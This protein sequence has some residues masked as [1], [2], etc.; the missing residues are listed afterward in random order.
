MHKPI[1]YPA[2][3]Q[4]LLDK[5]DQLVPSWLPN[6]TEKSGRWYIGDL[7]GSPGKSCNI[8]LHTG[9]WID[10]GTDEKGGDL[11]SLY[12]AIRGLQMGEAA[13]ELMD[14]LGLSREQPKPV[15]TSERPPSRRPE[16]PPADDKPAARRTMWRSV[17]P[18]PDNARPPDF[19]HDHHGKADQVWE[20]KLD[21]KLYGYVCRFDKPPS[22]KRPNGGKEIMPRTWCVD[23]SDGNGHQR[24]HWKQWDEPRP[25]Y[26]P[27][28]ILAEDSRVTPVVIVEGEKCAMAAFELL[29]HEFDFISWPGGGKAWSYADWSWIKGRVVYLWPDCDA[30]RERLTT[31]D[32]AAGVE[33]SSKPIMD[34]NRQP[35]LQTMVG[36]GSLLVADHGCTVLMCR[37]PAPGA[38]SDGWDVAD[39]I[40]SG[41]DADTV[42]GFIRGAAAFTPPSD[43]ARAKAAKPPTAPSDAGAGEVDDAKAWRS[44]LILSSTGAIKAVRENVVLA[45]DGM[46]G[47]PGVP[48]AQGVIAY[49]EFTNDIIKLKPTPWG[50][51]AGIWEEVD[52][53]LVG[54]WLVR[55]HW[56]PSM[57][58]GTL[59]EAI[60][61]VAYRH[62]YHP[63]RNWL[64]SLKWDGEKR[65]ATW[66]RRACLEEDEW[67]DT[68]PLQRYLA[69]VGTW[70][71]TGMC[72]RV[73]QP[74]YKFDYMLILEGS[75]GR[76][77]ST[78]L[79]TLAGDWFADTG[80]VLG[81][82]DS[83]QQLQGRWLYEFGE[84]DSFG[85][86]EV[87]KIKSFVASSS[88][89]FRASFDRRA[90]DYPRQVVFGGTTNEDHYLTDPTGNRRFWPV[91]V[92][93]QIDIDWIT[94][95]R[96]QLFAEAME[97]FR[98]GRRNFPLPEEEL[99]LFEPQ[100]RARAVE[101]AIESALYRHL[102]SEPEGLLKKEVT[103]I[104]A[105]G[106]IGIGLEKLGPGRFHEKQAAAALRRMGWQEG[107]ASE[108]ATGKRPRVYR[109]PDEPVPQRIQMPVGSE[110]NG[111]THDHDQEADDLIPF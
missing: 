95:H 14:E 73:M 11:I 39:A 2:L 7:D 33:R 59:E 48:E 24:W 88:D 9:T 25:L 17:V 20:Y 100:Q 77:K 75:Q 32:K 96:E 44:K 58:R 35:G 47:L 108:D 101:N 76:R 6:G 43:E 8:N 51:S 70:F 78:L 55:E 110:D 57:P 102:Y 56:L 82:K 40:A 61:M 72:A 52:E 109:R 98:A 93:R 54:E 36:I 89:Y 83:Y 15:Q 42:R 65:L 87:T 106:A 37:I 92:T 84:L 99:E 90:R 103:L 26:V 71:L 10:N 19:T 1:D 91:R 74:G 97:R 68:E 13:R 21:G 104:A 69:R 31:A 81:D 80:L 29:G 53:L 18:V 105:L 66:L 45:L 38:M 12:A 86:A 50:T 4:A 30:Q 62:R 64:Q 34:A 85:K 23:E 67:D 5:A 111:Q 16:P 49:N 27:A 60:R 94:E 28:T 41:W 46:Q 107:R 79:R 63:V 22:E 3:A